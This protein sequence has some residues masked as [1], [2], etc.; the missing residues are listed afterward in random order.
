M[1]KYHVAGRDANMQPVMLEITLDAQQ[2]NEMLMKQALLLQPTV[3]GVLYELQE[4]AI[5][6]ARLGT[7]DNGC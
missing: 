3:H 2:V 6:R 5:L 1:I 7:I 4:V